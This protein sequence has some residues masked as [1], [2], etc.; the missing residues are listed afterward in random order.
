VQLAE[1]AVQDAFALAVERWSHD[2]VPRSPGGW[3][4]TVARNRAVDRLRRARVGAAKAQ[5]AAR[6]QEREPA[7]QE[8]D[9]VSSIPDDRLSL[10]FMCCHPALAHDAQVALTL[11]L[12]GGLTTA[13]IARAF[14]MSEAT[15]AQR[16]VRAKRKIRAARIPFRVPPDHL[17]PERLAAVLAVLY[18]IFNEGYASTA[19]DTL[20]RRELA[21]EAIRLGRVLVA[22]MPDEPEARGLLA[23]M[24]LQHSRRDARVDEEGELVLLGEQARSRWKQPEIEEGLRLVRGAVRSRPGPYALQA[25]IAAVHAEAPSAEATDWDRIVA[26]YDELAAVAPGPVVELNRAVAVSM[27]EGPEV[28]L[29]LIGGIEGLKRYHLFH[30]ARA[31]LLRRLGR[32]EE[33]A[34]AYERALE[35]AT[36]AVER[37]FLRRRL[38]E[39]Q[40]SPRA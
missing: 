34:A 29:A 2:G 8:E 35:L 18:L 10:V 40:D 30:S 14:L 23:L 28:G 19:S 9:D 3:I 37:R 39:V 27:A 32:P 1:D 5:E 17:L 21:A 6:A 20:V 13:E 16:L 31:V 15:L 11:R 25:A 7:V 38:R 12:L 22:L 24:L 4:V 33:A 26:L 36:N